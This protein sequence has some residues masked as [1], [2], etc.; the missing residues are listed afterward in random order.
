M[1][2]HTNRREFFKGLLALSATGLVSA[3]CGA[4]RIP[5]TPTA[6]P[7][8]LTTIASPTA[9]AVPRSAATVAPTRTAIPARPA[10]ASPAP[11]PTV[12]PRPSPT[13]SAAVDLAVARGPGANPAELVRRAI[14]AIG[15]IER[16]FKPGAQVIIKPNICTPY[17]GPE[18]AA[19]TNPEVVAALV[20]LCL[21]AGAKRVRVM[22][23]PFGGPAQACYETSGI[24]A[25]VG[26]AG[27]R[28]EVM[29]Q[30]RFRQIDFPE[31]R[32]IKQWKVYRDILDADLVINAP[33]AK[34][35]G[36]AG[37]TLGMKNLMGVIEDRG[38]FH[39]R[40]LHQC[41]ADL[42]TAV[43]PQLTVIDAVR[44]L[45]RNG[46]TGGNLDD[47]KRLDAVIAS[48]DVVAA[49]AYATTFFDRQAAEIN[50]IRLAAEMGVGE[51]DLKAVRIEEITVE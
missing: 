35:H 33:I 48:T 21:G 18:Y 25:A 36:S 49:D 16:F 39:S 38:G 47:V 30:L 15:G 4:R 51:M 7:E 19:T 28:M 17:Y 2:A 8:P 24:E 9:P 12:T 40:G 31:G 37:L 32:T 44:I 26:A 3:A 42:S 6:L 27:G 1:S 43:K 10:A 34:H 22:D 11:R 20:T 46:P 29:N 13:S 14:A 45:M 23:F 41:I 5:V 50:Y